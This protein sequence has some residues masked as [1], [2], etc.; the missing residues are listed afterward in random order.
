MRYG[1]LSDVHANLAALEAVLETL[2]DRA[3]DRLLVAGDLVGYGGQPNE[4]VEL[5]AEVEA[6]CVAG[7]QDLFVLDRLPPTRFPRLARRS[8]ELT[9][10]VLVPATRLT[11]A[12]IDCEARSSPGSGGSG[13][14]VSTVRRPSPTGCRTSSSSVAPVSTF[15]T[16]TPLTAPSPG[17]AGPS[18]VGLD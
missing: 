2:K 7:H 4:C 16:P 11:R 12:A 10:S 1:L 5:L 6:D 9:R 17:R 13:P 18:Q 15:V 14:P 3:V 8:A